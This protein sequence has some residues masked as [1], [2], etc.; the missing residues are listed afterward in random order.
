MLRVMEMML[1][2]V[3][4][5]RN[6]KAL[7]QE[8]SNPQPSRPLSPANP[9]GVDF[10]RPASTAPQSIRNA[11]YEMRQNIPGPLFADFVSVITSIDSLWFDCRPR[12]VNVTAGIENFPDYRICV[13]PCR[14]GYCRL[15]L[16]H[17]GV[18]EDGFY[19][20]FRKDF[21][22]TMQNAQSKI[23]TWTEASNALCT[24]YEGAMTLESDSVIATAQGNLRAA[25]KPGQWCLFEPKP[26][27]GDEYFESEARM[28]DVIAP[29]SWGPMLQRA[30]WLAAVDAPWGSRD[31]SEFEDCFETV[32]G[33]PFEGVFHP[34][35]ELE[36][37]GIV[38]SVFCG[39]PNFEFAVD[40]FQ[41]T[42]N[43]CA[44]AY[45]RVTVTQQSGSLENSHSV[46][47][48]DFTCPHRDELRQ[49]LRNVDTVRTR[50][51][52][53]AIAIGSNR[54]G[55]GRTVTTGVTF[56]PNKWCRFQAGDALPR[57]AISLADF[58]ARISVW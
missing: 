51:P 20:E 36:I 29:F 58:R 4:H 24:K 39:T 16:T 22:D 9:P 47:C 32:Y 17:C 48:D 15:E 10:S 6:P 40:N 49:A 31:A 30:G 52:M 50:W 3:Q 46:P 42:I 55:S 41:F 2:V 5:N 25:I 38:G 14:F 12:Y 13:F 7:D 1:N 57:Y 54:D 19:C 45:C 27:R 8:D 26:R 35:V 23:R 43:P 53:K 33:R 44:H 21:T 56:K 18:T 11:D 28:L 37:L 34:A